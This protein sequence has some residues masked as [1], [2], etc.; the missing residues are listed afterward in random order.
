MRD[1]LAAESVK[2]RRSRLPWI[3]VIGFTLATVVSGLF[4]FIAQDPDRARSLGLAGAKA[5]MAGVTADWP[6]YLSLLGQAV[7]I[8]G[9]LVYGMTVI[10]VFGREFSDRT[11]KDLLAL[12]TSRVAIVA[13]KFTVAA[14]W[15]G[16]LA[17]YAGLLGLAVGAAL[18]LPGWSAGVAGAGIG[19][20]LAAAAL[21]ILVVPTLGLAASVGRGYLAAVGALFVLLFVTQI[22]AAL[23]YGN[24]FPYAVPGVV[25]G[26]AGPDQ[27][28]VGA[29]GYLLVAL[30]AVLST[31]ATALFWRNADHDR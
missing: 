22:L 14:A 9:F 25:S 6:S 23:G 30:V 5:Q 8:G 27:P 28:P 3:T 20:L 4:T 15:S 29:A 21:T 24:V 16:A 17:A 11:L 2:L 13:A 26:V 12:P 18:R 31:T 19:R 7:A 10:W 1:A